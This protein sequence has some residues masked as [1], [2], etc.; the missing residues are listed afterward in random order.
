LPHDDFYGLWKDY[1][2][3]EQAILYLDGNFREQPTLSE[4]ARSVHLSEYHFHRLFKRWAGI[5]PKQFLQFLT[6]EYAKNL[7]N[8][9]RSLLEVTYNSGLS[10]I[11]RLHDLFVTIDAVTPGEFKKKGG[12]LTIVYGVHLTP[13]GKCLLSVT[14]RGICGLSFVTEKNLEQSVKNLM[15]EWAGAR[16]IENADITRSYIDTIFVPSSKGDRR[17]LN[18]FLKGTNFQI[19]IWQALLSIPPEY[20]LSY[21]D[22]AQSDSSFD[23]LKTIGEAVMTNPVAYVIPCH[24]V[25]HRIGIVGPYRWG[26][27]RKRAMLGWEAAQKKSYTPLSDTNIRCVV[28]YHV[29]KKLEK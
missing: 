5:T 13:F 11:S 16:F 17:K 3:I 8:E 14:E 21:E 28:D 6:I 9:S 7:L 25:I 12:G 4:I 22:I 10:S 27:A 19:K 1:L 15:K 26:T 29:R 24:R 2:R 20:V 18:L 23:G